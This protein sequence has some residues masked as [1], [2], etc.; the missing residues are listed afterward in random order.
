MLKKMAQ[1]RAG[2]GYRVTGDRQLNK[3][4]GG[5]P[6]TGKA[7]VPV[8]DEQGRVGHMYAEGDPSSIV[9]LQQ[10]KGGLKSP[11]VRG[12]DQAR[13]RQDVRQPGQSLVELLDQL[14]VGG[15]RP[16]YLS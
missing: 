14:R 7:F 15:S 5:N 16:K 10:K 9:W 12:S 1:G 8:V 6:R 13:F 11:P 2:G 3:V 4:V